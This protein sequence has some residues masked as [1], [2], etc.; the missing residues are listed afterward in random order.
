M[1]FFFLLYEVNFSKN[2]E[3]PYERYEL[4][5]LDSMDD[6]EFRAEFRFGKTEIPLLRSY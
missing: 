1:N 3:F 6:T 5:D 4:F 2:P